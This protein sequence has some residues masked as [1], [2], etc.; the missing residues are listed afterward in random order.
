MITLSKS[1]NSVTFTFDENSGYLQNG[2]IDV[3][4]NSLA[5]IIDES[6]MATFRKSASNDIFI[7]ARYEEFGM[8]KA[9]LEAWYKANMVGSSGGDITSGEVQ[10]MIDESISGK[11][12]SVSAVSSAEYVSSSTTIN[13]K[14]ADG[15]VISSID[16]SDFV[17]DGMIDNVSIETISGASYLVINFNT[18]SGKEDIQIPL[19]DIFDPSNYYTK[20]EVD[21]SLSGKVDTS[22][23]T[24]YTAAT[25]TVLSGKQDTLTAGRAIDITSNVVSL[26]LPISA[27]TGVDSI[28]MGGSGNTAS[29]DFSVAYGKLNS[30]S[31]ECGL[32]NGNRNTSNNFAEAAFGQKNISRTEDASA[33]G[34]SGNTLFSVG[35]GI[36]NAEQ[37][38]DA[39]HN[40]FEVRGNGD[41]YIADTNSSGSYYEKPMIKL[42][43]HL[44]GGGGTVDQSI[45]SGS[46]NAVAGGAVFDAVNYVNTTEYWDGVAWAVDDETKVS[47]E[48]NNSIIR[49]IYETDSLEPESSASFDVTFEGDEQVYTITFYN[50]DDPEPYWDLDSISDYLDNYEWDGG[51]ELIITANTPFNVVSASTDA[52]LLMDVAKY[53][54]TT[55]VTSIKDKVNTSVN[56]ASINGHNNIIELVTTFNNGNQTNTSIGLYD[57]KTTNSGQLATDIK[58]PFGSGVWTAV[59]FVDSATKETEEINASQVK[60]T[61]TG[62]PSQDNSIYIQD[63]EDNWQTIMYDDDAWRNDTS[64][65]SEITVSGNDLYLTASEGSTIKKLAADE[66]PELIDSVEKFIEQTQDLIPYVQETK[67]DLGGLKLQQVTQAE[68]DAL[69]SGGTIDNSTLYVIT[70]S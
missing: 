53:S 15:T 35:N 28:L 2:T 18:A 1:G 47:E 39:N 7:S 42:Q 6:D 61:L 70:N 43:D 27:G 52:Q 14:N 32:A 31:G 12:D 9:E 56:G 57:L 8:S 54:E 62:T 33:F 69:V 58:V 16:A 22:T 65:L 46:T 17:I 45:I 50:T 67:S 44:G 40:A 68:Y 64:F 26:D 20:Q 36:I 30:V 21:A 51:V 29:G 19:T 4:I 10:T 5:L 60:I 3:P 41:I 37:G 11:A 55:T 38:I 23:Y 24:A 48:I 63:D 34:H 49:V 66:N 13:F 25:D 59:T